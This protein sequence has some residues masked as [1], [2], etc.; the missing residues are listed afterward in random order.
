M[1]TISINNI[2]ITP[3]ML[4]IISK[5]DS[6]NA[7]WKYMVGMEPERLNTL[8]K[9]ATIESIGSSNRIEGNRLSDRD[10]E[11]LLSRIGT[12]SFATRDEQEVAGYARLM[13]TLYDNFEILPL[14]ENYIKQ[15]HQILL[16]WSDKDT[17]HR[18]E[19]KSVSNSVMAYGP[20]GEE[21]GVVFQ[22]VSPFETP[23]QMHDLIHWMNEAMEEE[24][25]HPLLLI[26]IFIVHFLAVHPFQ[27]GNGRLSRALNALLLLKAGYS[28]IPYTSLE[29]IIEESKESYYRSLHQ[30]QTSFKSEHPDYTPWLTFFLRSLLKQ[31]QRLEKKIS[32]GPLTNLTPNELRVMD[33][34]SNKPQWALREIVQVTSMNINTV[35]KT[36]K[37]LVGKQ[38]L[39]L[40]GKGRNAN[41]KQYLSLK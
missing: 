23:E 15:F 35:K 2:F 21:L 18:G 24:P 31:K 34:F 19:Y 6:F 39:I 20:Q 26:G 29:T 30:T 28:Y 40:H 9:I 11:S 4:S 7:S 36:L 33:L 41:Y 25:L 22:T 5:I 1:L 38:F 12:E 37:S 13:D 14:T 17:R 3:E 16:S 10:V 27:D 8:R 32:V